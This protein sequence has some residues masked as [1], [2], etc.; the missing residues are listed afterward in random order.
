MSRFRGPGHALAKNAIKAPESDGYAKTI[1][2]KPYFDFYRP[3]NISWA[4]LCAE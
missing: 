4:L 2:C 3:D 1:G